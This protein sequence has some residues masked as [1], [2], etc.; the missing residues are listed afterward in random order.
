MLHIN[1]GKDLVTWMIKL[2]K[3]QFLI[4]HLKMIYVLYHHSQSNNTGEAEI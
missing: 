4:S 1:F 2:T 3:K